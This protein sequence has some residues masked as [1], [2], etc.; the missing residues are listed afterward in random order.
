[1]G[2]WNGVKQYNPLLLL[3]EP[4]CLGCLDPNWSGLCS[5]CR[6]ELETLDSSEGCSTCSYPLN[7]LDSEHL[8]K[9]RCQWCSRLTW[10][11][12]RVICVYAYR[13]IGADLFR[14]IKFEGY[15][16][17]IQPL[18]GLALQQIVLQ[19]PILPPGV[20]VPIPESL[21][22]RLKRPQHPADVFARALSQHW[23]LPLERHLAWK[24]KGPSQVGLDY[25]SRRSNIKHR[26]GLSKVRSPKWNPIGRPLTVPE[27][28]ILVDDVLTTG[29]T[30]ESVTR[31]LRKNGAKQIIWVTL[32][33]TL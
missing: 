30:L 28:V 11:P 5:I 33:R 32:F 19:E 18:L 14:R 3:G 27:K 23:G 2:F 29:A 10:L 31:L 4:V 9:Q 25:A 6:E 12:D 20:I 24:R 1:M 7:T 13:H 22:S 16:R 8:H 26:F 21:A 15:W 17:G